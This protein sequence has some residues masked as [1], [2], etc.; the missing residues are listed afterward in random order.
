MNLELS[1]LEPNWFVERI[2]KTEVSGKSSIEGSKGQVGLMNERKSMNELLE[3]A[4]YFGIYLTRPPCHVR[5]AT[6]KKRNK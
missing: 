3:E 2:D 6:D 1:F 4:A 5:L